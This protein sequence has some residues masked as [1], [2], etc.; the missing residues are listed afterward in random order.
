MKKTTYRVLQGLSVLS[1][2]LFL[3]FVGLK[4]DGSVNWSWWWVFAPVLIPIGVTLFAVAVLFALLN[5]LAK[6]D[7]NEK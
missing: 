4:L 5:H 3:L 1:V 2:A 6:Q 7:K